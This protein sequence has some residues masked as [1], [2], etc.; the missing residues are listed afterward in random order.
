M[1]LVILTLCCLSLPF[2]FSPASAKEL[3]VVCSTTDLADI[4]ARVGGD[5]VEA[6]H[7]VRASENPHFISARPSYVRRLASADAFVVFGL[8]LEVGW[9][10]ALL[11]SA[12]NRTIVPGAPGYIDCSAAI[13]ILQVK[14]G[15]LDRSQGDVHPAGNPHYLVSPMCGIQVAHYLAQRLGALAPEHQEAFQANA[16]Q[17]SQEVA[18]QLYGP[19]A[20]AT[21][22]VDQL[23]DWHEAGTLWDQVAADTLGGWL[24]KLAALRGKAFLG[25]HNQWP[26]L[27]ACFGFEMTE[28]LEPKAGIAPSSSH[29]KKIISQAQQKNHWSGILTARWF[30]RRFAKRVSEATGLP[31][32]RLAHQVGAEKGSE[33]FLSMCQY[34]VHALAQLESGASSA[35]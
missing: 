14:T 16:D 18:E 2:L 17:F 25:D 1:R 13:R 6:T 15:T 5:A 22:G 12:R 31:V 19:V 33:T 30:N 34:N 24:N 23:I 27:A 21:H 10:P 26:Y 4:V 9:A 7:L 8:E 11:R 3:Q 35:P 29:L 32:V 20:V 28:H